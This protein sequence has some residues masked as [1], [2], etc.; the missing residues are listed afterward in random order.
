[1]HWAEGHGEEVA[2]GMRNAAR[3]LPGDAETHS[4]VGMILAK[5]K[6][7]NEAD[8]S[9]RDA[10]EIDPRFAAARYRQGMSYELQG[11]YAEAEVSLRA[12]VAL[13][14]DPLTADD[15]QGYS[16]LLYIQ[17]YNP[18]LDAQALF[19]EHRRVGEIFEAGLKAHWPPHRNSRAPDRRLEV[20]FVSGDLRNHALA[21]FLEPVLSHLCHD[22]GLQLHAY[23][24]SA[25]EDEVSARLKRYVKHWHPVARLPDTVL[26][27]QI[28][29]DGIDM[30]IDL[31]G[32]TGM[33]RMRTFA[34]KP[35][36]VQA[37][38]MGYPGTSGLTAMDYFLTDR[39]WLPRD[40]FDRQFVE[41]LVY[42][43]ASASF[44]PEAAAPPVNG[45]PALAAGHL[46]F[47][48]FNRLCKI[49]AASIRVWSQLLHAL[50][51]A[52]VILAGI[53]P[54]G[55]Q[56]L[57]RRFEDEGIESKRLS[58]YPRIPMDQYL[59]LHHRVDI[60]LDTFPYGGATTT[61][62][63]LWMGVPTLTVAGATPAGRQGAGILGLAGLD[64]FIAADPEDFVAKGIRWENRLTDLAA[65]RS[66]V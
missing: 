19:L 34:R 52:A 58:M 15:E 51:T 6:H 21:S 22:G 24:N 9:L 29:G 53:D 37:S 1:M 62:H 8:A 65:L 5:M 25:L 10:I 54:E 43:P 40:A 32:H 49:N 64:G 2:T 56:D 4:N 39:H 38:W 23:S 57:V 28:V 42:L 48:S 41:K 16:N 3:L 66:G 60:C 18:S 27:Q 44:R 50:P 31:S 36:P 26:A 7:F 46:T 14:S 12:A 30:L 55:Q 45:L 61:H 47:G 59:A 63:A 35:A 33:N 11:R 20:G 13:R 17:S